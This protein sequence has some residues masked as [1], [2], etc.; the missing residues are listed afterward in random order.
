PPEALFT[1]KTGL[2]YD[3]RKNNRYHFNYLKMPIGLDFIIGKK[4]NFIFGGG[5]YLSYFF[6][7]NETK[8]NSYFEIT[9]SRLQLGGEVNVGFGYQISEKIKAYLMCQNNNDITK[10][11]KYK[12]PNLAGGTRWEYVRG[13]DTFCKLGI[14]YNINKK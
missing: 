6:L 3:F 14:K 2:I 10:M 11:Y 8:S 7:Y 5:F 13:I 1:I 9:I 4:L 12:R